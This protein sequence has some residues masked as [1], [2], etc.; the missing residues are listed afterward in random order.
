M[1]SERLLEHAETVRKAQQA[2]RELARL[3]ALIDAGHGRLLKPRDQ[4]AE[5]L[6]A[7]RGAA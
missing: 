5:K 6:A 4:L 2:E 7:L 1:S 3:D